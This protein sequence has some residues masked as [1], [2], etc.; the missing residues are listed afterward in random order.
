[1]SI[2]ILTNN[3]FINIIN[4]INVDNVIMEYFM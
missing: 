1:M 2:F 4:K 3:I